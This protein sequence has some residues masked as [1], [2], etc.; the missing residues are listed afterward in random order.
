ME[1][2]KFHLNNPILISVMGIISNIPNNK[3][4]LLLVIGF[5]IISYIIYLLIKLQYSKADIL[6]TLGR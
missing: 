4:S 5:M 1:T 6:Q 3:G 2:G